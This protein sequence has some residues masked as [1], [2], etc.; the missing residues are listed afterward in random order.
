MSLSSEGLLTTRTINNKDT[1]NNPNLIILC[2]FTFREKFHPLAKRNLHILPSRF[3]SHIKQI[4]GAK[5]SY[6]LRSAVRLLQDCILHLPSLFLG[7]DFSRRTKAE[8]L[9]KNQI[10]S[11]MFKQIW[12][13]FLL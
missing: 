1:A 11:V 9:T 5:V 13:Y 6:S 8:F 4:S 3:I 10:Y 7:N 2:N 12:K